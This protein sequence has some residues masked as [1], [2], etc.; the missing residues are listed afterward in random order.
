M[1]SSVEE[2]MMMMTEPAP[3]R[4]KDNNKMIKRL[5]SNNNIIR[6]F[7]ISNQIIRSRLR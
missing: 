5:G 7:G 1:V 6:R 2:K 4:K 3:M